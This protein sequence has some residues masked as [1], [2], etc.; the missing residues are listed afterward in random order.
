[1]ARVLFVQGNYDLDLPKTNSPWMPLALVELATFVRERGHKVKILDRNLYP[2]D[3]LFKKILNNFNPDIVG[4]TCYT[5]PVI[6]DVKHISKLTKNNSSSIVVVGGIHATLEPKSLLECP[7]IDYVVR[8]EGEFPLL[9]ICELFDKKKAT[10]TNLSKIKNI[11]YNPL[12]PIINLNALPVPDY[13][14]LEVKKYP[15]ATFCTSRGCPGRCR[16]CY[17][18]G[19][20]LRFYNTEKV[21]QMIDSVLS[22]YNIKE[23][24]IADDNF[25]NLSKRT[26]RICNAISKYDAIFHIFLR[27]D[28]TDDKIMMNLK[29]AGCWSIQFGFETGSQKMLDFLHKDTTIQQNIKAI[30]QCKKYDI[31][32]DGSFMIGLPTET[33]LELKETIDFIRQNNPSAVDIKIYKPFP[34]TD[35]FNYCIKKGLIKKPNSLEDWVKFSSLNKGE[36]NL[37]EI[38]LN[39]LMKTLDLFS[40]TSNLIYLKKFLILLK[41][42]HYKYVLF[43]SRD[44]VK[45]KIKTLL[46][47]N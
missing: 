10:K 1:M 29:K 17:N 44:I 6:K 24:T 2:E 15:I 7:S 38:S 43:K 36:P 42:K 21:I 4:I 35:L 27:V 31:F 18:L 37:S 20:Q 13:D 45:S 19:R 3:S 26:E 30:K 8:G 40:K 23:F 47:K 33:E 16:F 46:R 14:L 12:R 32:V 34:S 9:E 39:K 11:N 41:K 25:A 28:Q 22:K 5:S